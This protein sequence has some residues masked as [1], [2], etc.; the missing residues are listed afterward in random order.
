MLC[1]KGRIN[2][3]KKRLHVKTNMWAVSVM[4]RVPLRIEFNFD[5]FHAQ[6]T[7]GQL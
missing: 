4:R 1:A 5:G 6:F 3:R 2:C 7:S